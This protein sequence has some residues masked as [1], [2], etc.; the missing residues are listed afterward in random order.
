MVIPQHPNYAAEA[1]DNPGNPATHDCTNSPQ[2]IRSLWDE[3]HCRFL[4]LAA[5]APEVAG[6]HCNSHGQGA[7]GASKL[8]SQL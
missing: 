1:A 6:L 2:D 7:V 8:V 4:D 3:W 5:L